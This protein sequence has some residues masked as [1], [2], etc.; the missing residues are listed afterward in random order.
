ME[1][2]LAVQ[3]VRT[4][5][6]F[7]ECPDSDQAMALMSPQNYPPPALPVEIFKI[8]KTM[9]N[10]IIMLGTPKLINSPKLSTVYF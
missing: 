9:H 10:W 7:N 4:N 5:L 8:V 3:L 6:T 1:D 2:M